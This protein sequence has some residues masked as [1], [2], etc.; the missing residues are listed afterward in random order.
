[1][2]GAATLHLPDGLP[3]AQADALAA[4]TAEICA[5]D[6]PHAAPWTAPALLLSD[7][8][9]RHLLA[10]P[11][12]AAGE[13]LV[14]DYQSFDIAA[15][16]PAG[17]RIFAK[18]AR[19]GSEYGLVLRAD[20]GEVRMTSALRLLPA[21]DIAAA[22]PAPFRTDALRGAVWSPPLAIDRRRTDRYLALSG[23]ANPIHRS[24]GAAAAS[25][26]PAPVVPGLLLLALIQPFAE[27]ALPGR[28]LS[29]LTCRFMSPLAVGGSARVAVMPRGPG[30]ARAVCLGPDARALAIA[31][32]HVAGG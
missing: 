15:P 26:L 1:M 12:A 30:R 28:S 20:P 5:P 19:N 6:A 4:L 25:G 29:R 18:A 3:A 7:P 8:A 32:L 21:A 31:D 13:V 14:H 24:A 9:V 22:R 10:L 17:S 16:L 27:R 2:T 11:E 23:D